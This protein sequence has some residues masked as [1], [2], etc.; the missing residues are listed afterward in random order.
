M[1]FLINNFINRTIFFLIYNDFELSEKC[2]P[3]LE[4]GS[5]YYEIGLALILEYGTLERYNRLCPLE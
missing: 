3:S 1:R 4:R 5:S 2:S